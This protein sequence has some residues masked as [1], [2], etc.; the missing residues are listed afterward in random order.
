MPCLERQPAAEDPHRK[1]HELGPLDAADVA[2]APVGR[3]AHPRPVLV[4]PVIAVDG[5]RGTGPQG[6]ADKKLAIFTSFY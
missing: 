3:A 1:A 4:G 5:Q 6:W 2:D